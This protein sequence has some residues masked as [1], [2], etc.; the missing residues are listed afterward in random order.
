MVNCFDPT[1]K[2]RLGFC[3]NEASGGGEK[4]GKL[5]D[6]GTEIQNPVKNMDKNMILC[7]LIIMFTNTLYSQ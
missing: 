1:T 7:F 4:W 3:E 6:M 5:D 2:L